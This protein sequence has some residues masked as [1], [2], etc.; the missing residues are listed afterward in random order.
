MALRVA[1]LT[2][3][4]LTTPPHPNLHDTGDLNSFFEKLLGST[5]G[6]LQ[7]SW[8]VFTDGVKIQLLLCWNINHVGGK[9]KWGGSSIP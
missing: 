5:T 7:T 1:S 3:S 4:Q 9:V 2:M 6:A 8:D